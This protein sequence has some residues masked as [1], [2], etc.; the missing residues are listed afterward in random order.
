[1]I[2]FLIILLSIWTVMNFTDY[3]LKS[4]MMFPYIAWME[5][6]GISLKL[7]RLQI[8]S[9]R[10]NR[11]IHLLGRRKSR[12]LYWWFTLGTFVSICAVVPSVWI[13]IT[14]AF[15]LHSNRAEGGDE[16]LILQPAMPGI[17]LPVT[18]I[19]YY[20]CTLV[21]CSVIHEF[22]H[23]LSAV[24]ENVRVQG[25][26]IFVL[27]IFPGAYVDMPKDQL[28]ALPAWRQL[29]I[30]CAGIWHNIVLI[31]IAYLLLWCA[32]VSYK[33]LY[34]EHGGISV[35][36]VSGAS[37]ATGPS[38]LMAGDHIVG[39]DNCTVSDIESWKSCLIS[40]IR[41]PQYG[42]CQK[43]D[44]VQPETT[45]G[46]H[47]DCC[48]GNPN[49]LCF[50]YTGSYVKQ[51]Q[52]CLPA[53]HT[54]ETAT[55]LCNATCS[56]GDVCLTPILENG[57]KLVQVKRKNWKTMLFLGHPSELWHAATVSRWVPR[58]KYLSAFPL[59]ACEVFLN[60]VIGFS[61]ALA[62]LNSIPCLMLDGQ[63]ILQALIKMFTQHLPCL[64]RT[65]KLLY[66]ILVFAGTFLLAANVVLGFRRLL[67]QT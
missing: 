4:C 17:N 40:A 54:I 65:R 20:V 11:P 6:N 25:C 22:G 32:P 5:R 66:L 39:V 67:T 49:S 12:F 46:S 35:I 16:A 23:A 41:L 37:G 63:W 21:I 64:K 15:S 43:V 13:L 10:F 60:Y 33:P 59:H 34:K 44:L 28:N 52:V 62:V 61:G 29:K 53:R 57:T 51:N 9:T 47:G 26:G 30:Y 27:G 2:I 50:A 42:L 56:G 14:T 1:M 58:L 36:S 19:L 24:R 38:G 8:Y 31:L 18:D 48:N 45:S 55:G 7:L 3:M